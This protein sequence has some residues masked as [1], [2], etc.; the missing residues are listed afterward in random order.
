MPNKSLHQTKPFVMHRACAPSAP[1]D[2]AAEADVGLTW[3]PHKYGSLEEQNA[4]LDMLLAWVEQ[5][6]Q[7]T[8]EFSLQA[9]RR[10][11]DNYAGEKFEYTSNERPA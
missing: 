1:T 2:F 8:D 6:A 3:E 5:Y 4:N 10:I 7:R 9:H 11:F